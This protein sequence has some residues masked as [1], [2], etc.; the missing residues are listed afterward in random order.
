MQQSKKPESDGRVHLLGD[1]KETA[2]SFQDE[3]IE[4]LFLAAHKCQIE[5]LKDLCEQSLISKLNVQ[6]AV[7]YLIVAHLR[8][9]PLLLEASLEFLVEH[10]KE[11]RTR[12][13]WNEL[14]NNHPDL[15]FLAANRRIG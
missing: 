2:V 11:V 4:Q 9:A 10:K 13:E 14:L 3:I 6:K 15:F 7:H 8:T 12:P 1:E 5:A